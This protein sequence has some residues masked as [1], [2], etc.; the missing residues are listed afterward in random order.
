MLK[1]NWGGGESGPGASGVSQVA[2][3]SNPCPQVAEWECQQLQ[4]TICLDQLPIDPAPYRL[5]EKETLYQVR[6]SGRSFSCS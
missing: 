3:L 2:W 6:F 5:L 1:Q 4:E